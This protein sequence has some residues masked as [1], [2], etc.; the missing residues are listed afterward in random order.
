MKNEDLEEK[1]LM[2]FEKLEVTVDSSNV[3]N[4]HWL[5]SNG[6]KNF[7]IKLS[8]RKNANKIRRV[9]KNLRGMN[10]SSLGIK[11]P[12]YINDSLCSCYKRVYTI[13]RS[14]DLE[15]FFSGNGLS[16]DVE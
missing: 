10:L 11:I 4:H 13:T 7:I 8:N 1:V 3:E 6:N 16:L 12:V 9:K 15:E 5:P 14:N 2:I